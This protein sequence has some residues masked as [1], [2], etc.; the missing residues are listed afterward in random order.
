MN[1]REKKN[2]PVEDLLSSLPAPPAPED[3][4]RKILAEIPE[5]LPAAIP[6]PGRR[7]APALPSWARI[8]A[9][10]VLAVAGGYVGYRLTRPRPEAPAPVAVAPQ[11]TAKL[12]P[13][14]AVAAV[15]TPPV[16]AVPPRSKAKPTVLEAPGPAGLEGVVTD[17]S[18]ATLPGVT[19]TVRGAAVDRT[20]TTD[21]RG[22]ISVPLLPAGRYEVETALAGFGKQIRQIQ[23]APGETKKIDSIL[24]L[25]TTAEVTVVSA[26]PLIDSRSTSVGTNYGVAALQKMPGKTVAG[27]VSV[28]AE[29]VVAN[30]PSAPPSTG[31][32]R[33]PNDQPYGDVFFR[34]YGVNPFIDTEDDHLSTFGL[35]VDTGSYAITR[36]YLADGNLPPVEAIRV[37]EFVNSFSYGDRPPSRG[38]FAITAEAAPTPFASGERYR[39]IRFH[40]RARD[41]DPRDRKP[42][43]LTFVVDVSGSMAEENRLELVKKALN[44]LLTQL[45]SSDRVGLVVFGTNARALLEPTSDHEAIGQAIDRLVPEGSTNTE[46]GLRLGYDMAVRHR[47]EDGI[48]RVILCSDGVA[49]VGATGPD[50]ILSVIERQVKQ[51]IE[52]TTVGF[53]M[54]NYNDVLME[55]LANKGNGRYAYVDTLAEARRIFVE[56]LT[57]TLQ[58]IAS[59]AKVQVDFDPSVVARYRL[60]GYENR[61][62]ADEK[63]RDDRVDAGEIGAGHE[64]TA[65]YEIKLAEGAGSG[66]AATIHLRYRSADTKKIVEVEQPLRVSQFAASWSVAPRGLRLAGLVAEFAEI[67]RHSYWAKGADLP[68]LARRARRIERDFPGDARVAEF[69]GLVEKAAALW[70]SKASPPSDD[71]E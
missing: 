34:T 24:N 43:V 71:Q 28:D 33:E 62:I 18:G 50:S 70:P 69:A 48:N 36:R 30:A 52:L 55:Q 2:T 16:I 13:P 46:E 47:R 5:Q 41:V 56:N 64:V 11:P 67:L 68:D 14:Q 65:I 49:N 23:V 32:T 6:F 10:I 35:D 21:A 12:A 45:R 66:T 19:V 38:D 31:G 29:T 9:V 7:R 39:I 3:L 51:G 15:A 8:A 57:G 44:L 58:T 17:Q 37:E 59:D 40:L 63:F 20:A 27:A 4:A 25:S 61:D 53:G 1:S 22:R 42:A 60:L 26:A 54:G